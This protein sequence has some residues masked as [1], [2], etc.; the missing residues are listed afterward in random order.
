[1]GV[2]DFIKDAGAKVFGGKEA[3][4]VDK[5]EPIN[6]ARQAYLKQ[7]AEI[8]AAQAEAASERVHEA[9]EAAALLALLQHS[10]FDTER[11]NLGYDDGVVT[12]TG[13]VDTQAELESMVLLI[14]NTVGVSQVDAQVEVLNPAPEATFY[15]VQKGDNLSKISKEFYGKGSRYREIF[16][17]NKPMLS[18]P[19]RIYPGQVL[20]IPLDSAVA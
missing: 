11:L 13:A 2:F 16:E 4:A 14:G 15:T 5:P 20:R 7:Q 12:V 1:M 10:G 9:A 8:A 19:D 18:D 17:A 3:E 6:Y